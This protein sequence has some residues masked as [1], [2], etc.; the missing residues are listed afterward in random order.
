MRWLNQGVY[1][2]TKEFIMVKTVEDSPLPAP[3]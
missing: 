3:V 1:V 2:K